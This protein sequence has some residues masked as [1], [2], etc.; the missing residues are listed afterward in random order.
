MLRVRGLRL[1]HNPYL[2]RTRSWRMKMP[3][4]DP[5]VWIDCEMTGLDHSRDHIIE[6]CCIV[7]DGRLAVAK[8]PVTGEDNCYE[9]VVHYDKSVMD[10]MNDWCVEQHGKSGLTAQVLASHSTLEQVQQG[11]LQHVQRYIPAKNVGVLAGNSVH[12]DRL[13]LLREFPQLTDHLFYRIIDVSSIMEVCKRHNPALAA[14]LPRK[15]TRHTARSDILESIAQLRWYQ[16]NYFKSGEETVQFVN[17]AS[18]TTVSYTD[19]DTD[20]DTNA[21][22]NASVDTN[23]DAKKRRLDNQQ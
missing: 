18:E 4:K 20:T 1:Y 12:V 15:V 16:D 10:G 2:S 13:F 21:N 19:T 6:I 9:S 5:I 23:S 17:A 22:A 8:D 11:L 7:T 14:A 3:V